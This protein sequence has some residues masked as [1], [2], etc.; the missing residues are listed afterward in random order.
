MY[1]FR[2][3]NV[4]SDEKERHDDI[5]LKIVDVVSLCDPYFAASMWEDIS[6]GAGSRT[7]S[8]IT[9][10]ASSNSHSGGTH[11]QQHVISA[12]QSQFQ[13]GPMVVTKSPQISNSNHMNP[14]SNA[15]VKSKTDLKICTTYKC[16]KCNVHAPVLAS[17]VE[18]LRISHK[19]IEKLFLCPYCRQYE[20]ATEPDVHRHIKQFHQQ[21]KPQNRPPVALS[22]AAKK[23]LRTIQVPAGDANKVGDKYVI[24]TDIYKCLKCN[25][26]MPS[27]DFIYNHI[28]KQ[29][30]EFFVNVCP[31]CK[32]FKS[33]DEEVVF[34]HIRQVHQ[35]RTED[36]T[37]SVAIEENLFTRVQC[38]VKTKPTLP[39]KSGV[40]VTSASS[41]SSSTMARN[42][43]PVSQMTHVSQ[44]TPPQA[45]NSLESPGLAQTVNQHQVFIPVEIQARPPRMPFPTGQLVTQSPTQLAQ[46]PPSKSSMQKSR[47][48]HS[49]RSH[50]ISSGIEH[51]L[52]KNRRMS[53]SHGN[54][55]PPPLLRAPPPL[56]RFENSPP[57]VQG[58]LP[59]SIPQQRSSTSAGSA[60]SPHAQSDILQHL[61]SSGKAISPPLQHDAESTSQGRPVLRVPSV[62]TSMASS[63]LTRTPPPRFQVGPNQPR[64]R[65]PIGHTQM[66]GTRQQGP[67]GPMYRF[68]TP[69]RP[70]I[71]R[72]STLRA[73]E[74]VDATNNANVTSIDRRVFKCP[75]C[76]QVVPL[77]MSDVAPHIEK[78]H[79]GHTIVF[80]KITD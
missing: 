49:N 1:R 54:D 46:Q 22:S 30:N 2:E 80:S 50:A 21:N 17:M 77:N 69:L 31:Y 70:F 66:G 34:N 56:L 16:E 6:Q 9:S 72:S 27:L 15:Q 45:V 29:H 53:L 23:Q 57:F 33:K 24:E 48:Q 43:V 62:R 14:Q 71:P 26:H 28:E 58:V 36:I 7:M 76:T 41:D 68:D 61:Q 40:Q 19:D 44:M 79:P 13:T 73:P 52:A 8:P 25:G 67:T 63:P 11:G 38:L 55:A 47:P 74:G 78:F 10:L 18:H 3:G 59:Q 12:L 75:Y 37:L 5:E 32:V 60:G 51:S 20:G 4:Q 35:R 42:I 39:Q 65:Y 64:M